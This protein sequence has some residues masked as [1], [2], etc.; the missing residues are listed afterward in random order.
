MVFYQDPSDVT[1]Q[2][3]NISVDIPVAKHFSGVTHSSTKRLSGEC[4]SGEAFQ[5]PVRNVS[6]AY[7]LSAKCPSDEILSAMCFSVVSKQLSGLGHDDDLQIFLSG[8][9]NFGTL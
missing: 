7:H 1:S 5:W 9:N 2:W 6:V 8:D 4:P 3:R